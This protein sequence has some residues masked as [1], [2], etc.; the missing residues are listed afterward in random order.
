VQV[1]FS[2]IGFDAVATMA[3]E[4]IKPERDL[5][6]GIEGSVILTTVLYVGMAL[7]LVLLQPYQV[8]CGVGG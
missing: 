1:F 8:C 3:E 2:Y 6:V 5:P 4:V 7:A